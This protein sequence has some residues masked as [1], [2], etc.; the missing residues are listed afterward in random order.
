MPGG[1]VK[2]KWP[3]LMLLVVLFTAGCLV[4][5]FFDQ[6]PASAICLIVSM[7]IFFGAIY[8]LFTVR[9]VYTV[10]RELAG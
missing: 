4:T 8:V 3:F 10:I 9:L 2:R 7:I 6:L 1:V 5:P